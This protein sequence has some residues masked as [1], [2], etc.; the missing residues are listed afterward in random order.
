MTLQD[1][2]GRWVE[3]ALGTSVAM[4]PHLRNGAFIEE[5]MELVQ[6]LGLTR[7]DCLQILDMVYSRPPGHPPQEVGGVMITLL[8]L[9]NAHRFGANDLAEIELERCWWNIEKIRE[10][11]KRKVYV[12]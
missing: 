10:N 5:A 8:A 1:R 4:N 6:S 3:A 12:R 9:C 11:Q 7:N 2:V